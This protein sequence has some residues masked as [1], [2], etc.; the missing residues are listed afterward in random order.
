M[1]RTVLLTGGAGYIGSHTFVALVEAGYSVVIVDDFSNSKPSV[2]TR[3]GRLTGLNKVEAY[4]GSVLDDAFMERVFNAHEF[5]AVVHFAAKKAVGESVSYPVDYVE[6][7]VGGLTTLLR[8]M[9]AHDVRRLVFSSS[10]TVYGDP[11]IIPIPES[12]PRSYTSPY[13]FTKLMSEQILEQAAA[14]DPAWAFGILR[15]FNPVGAHPSGTIG[16][17]PS[18]IPN[19]LMPYIAKV[20]AGELSHLNVFGDD[21]DTPD[22]TGVRDYVH[23]CDLAMGHVKSLDALMASNLGHTVNLGTGI[24]SSVFDMLQAYSRACGKTLPHVVTDRRDGDVPVLCAEVD[25]AR[26]LLG[27]EA[28]RT[29]DEMCASSWHWIQTGAKE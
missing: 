20:A 28:K 6:T 22:G 17:D 15:Y 10:A 25:R 23:V 7:N 8:L 13:A 11:D 4:E 14:A 21:Y 16:E 12:A 18:D 1:T 2:L 27:F 29:L 19:N 26:E 3:L 24:G 5:D 9:D